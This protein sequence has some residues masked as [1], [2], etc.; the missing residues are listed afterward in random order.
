M[1]LAD[2]SGSLEPKIKSDIL[3]D[4]WFN[5]PFKADCSLTGFESLAIFRRM[6]K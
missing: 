6:S 3:V 4:P 1:A 5:N 2:S